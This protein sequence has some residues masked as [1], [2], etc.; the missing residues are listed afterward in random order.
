MERLTPV[1]CKTYFHRH[2]VWLFPVFHGGWSKSTPPATQGNRH[3]PLSATHDVE[4][5]ETAELAS[6]C[7]LHKTLS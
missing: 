3:P 5:E 2:L 4:S 6:P 7:L 1:Q